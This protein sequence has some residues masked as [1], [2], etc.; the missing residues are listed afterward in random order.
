MSKLSF[1]W[2]CAGKCLTTSSLGKRCQALIDNVCSFPWCKHS[3]HGLFQAGSMLLN[4][5]LGRDV[6]NHSVLESLCR[7]TPAH[8]S[9]GAGKW[10]LQG[11]TE[12]WLLSPVSFLFLTEQSST[13]SSKNLYL[14]NKT[15]TCPHLAE[16]DKRKVVKR[17]QIGGNCPHYRR[18]KDTATATPGTGLYSCFCSSVAVSHLK[19]IL[20]LGRRLVLLPKQCLN[21]ILSPE[22]S[23]IS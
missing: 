6:H 20:N 14:K 5:E 9:F 15:K 2:W 22:G 13:G 21:P 19:P 7:L 11:H 16:L 17:S 4:V 8:L 18:R 3:H 23:Y 10:Q 12:S 1:W